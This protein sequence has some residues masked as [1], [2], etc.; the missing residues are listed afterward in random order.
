MKTTVKKKSRRR[1][2]HYHKGS[3]VSTKTGQDC[4]FRS[5]WEE[6]FMKYLDETETVK[7]WSY[8]SITIDYLSNK[9]TAKYRKYY[10][11][12]KV[13]YADGL[14]EIIEIKPKKRL[15]QVV[16]KKKLA[17]ALEWCGVHGFTLRIITEI[18]L[19]ELGI[20]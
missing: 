18:E 6:K 14:I 3:Y 4:K 7:S 20:L 8:E 9:R 13:E 16:V 11:D 5:G 17:A 12:F 1:R 10:P 15:D 19:K 2:S